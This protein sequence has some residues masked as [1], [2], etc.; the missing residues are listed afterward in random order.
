M[1]HPI[2]LF[3]ILGPD[4]AARQQY[5][6]DLFGWEIDADNAANYGMVKDIPRHRRRG[7]SDGPSIA[8]FADPQGNVIGLVNGM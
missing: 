6:A 1:A 4:G 7:R 8:M 5:D 2:V 3:E